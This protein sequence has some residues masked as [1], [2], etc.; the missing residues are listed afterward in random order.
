MSYK[1]LAGTSDEATTF[2]RERWEDDQKNKQE[3]VKLWERCAAFTNGNQQFINTNS[4]TGAL[5]SSNFIVSQNQDTR[6]QMFTTNEIDPIMRTIVSYMTRAQPG[7]TIYPQDHTPQSK[8]RAEVAEVVHNAKYDMDDEQQLSRM[9]AY[10]AGTY[11]TVIRKDYW[12]GMKGR[13]VEIPMYDDLGNEVTDPETGQVQVQALKTGDSAVAI[14]TPFSVGF[15]WSSPTWD[16]TPYIQESYLMPIEWAKMAFNSTEPG[17]TG[18][19]D[20]IQEGTYLSSSLSTLEQLKYA[21]PYSFSTQTRLSVIGKALIVEHHIKPCD[22]IP[23]GRLIITAND[24]TVYDSGDIGTPYFMAFPKVMW[25]PYTFFTYQ[26]YVGRLLGKGLVEGVIPQQMR[27]NEINGSILMNANT[28]AKVDILAVK[29]QLAKGIL[30]G[31]GSNVYTF[32]EVPSGF[33]P[34]KWQG[35]PLPAQFWT[36]KEQL[37]EQMV[38]QVGTNFAMSGEPPKGV[39]AA[40]AIQTLLDNASSQQSD[41]MIAWKKFHE[42]AYFKKLRLIRKFSKHNNQDMIDYIRT[43]DRSALDRQ[44]DTF[45]GEDLGDGFTLKVSIESMLPKSEISRRS[46]LMTFAQ[47]QVW[48]PLNDGSPRAAQVRKEL[49]ERFGEKDIEIDENRDIEK[50]NWENDQIVMNLQPAPDI[51]DNPEIHLA[52]HIGQKKDPKFITRATPEMKQAMEQHIQWHQVQQPIM[53]QQKAIAIQGMMQQMLPQLGAP[54]GAP[55]GQAPMQG[56]EGIQNEAESVAP[57]PEAQVLQ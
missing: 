44:I 47:M 24:V 46:D 17:Y 30:N 4:A 52:C 23:R 28:V 49:L 7:I 34:T 20:E 35:A 19:V 25:N 11:G 38:R 29:G 5:T 55:Q 56:P 14:L 26:P 6:Q 39:T 12:D 3:L 13:D 16:E 42:E 37:I 2:L 27:L 18:R 22:G 10:Y 36:E 15:D 48:G 57:G 8:D 41:T 54:Q 1:E 43:M 33:T 45:V 21:T 53:I 51:D 32:K 31:M 50:A 9:A 40:S